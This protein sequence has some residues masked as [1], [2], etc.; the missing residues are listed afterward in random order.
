MA[1][2]KNKIP[3]EVN[4]FYCLTQP[5]THLDESNNSKMNGINSVFFCLMLQID[6]VVETHPAYQEALKEANIR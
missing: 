5:D 1:G 4:H 3:R 6:Y 2:N